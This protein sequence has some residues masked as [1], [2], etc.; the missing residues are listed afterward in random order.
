M[1]DLSQRIREIREA[2]QIGIIEARDIAR[3]EKLL[4]D[5]QS[6]ETVA[7]LRRIVFHIAR[8]LPLYHS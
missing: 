4:A 3:R 2:R 6:A 1:G 8:N 5:I 7:D